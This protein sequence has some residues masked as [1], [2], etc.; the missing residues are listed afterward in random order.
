MMD[1]YNILTIILSG[2]TVGGIASAIVYRRQNKKL[3]ENEVTLSTVEAQRE[4]MN[5]GE[6]YIKKVMELSELNY[7]NTLK[8][9]KD[10]AVIIEKV[11]ELAAEQKNIVSYL[12][13]DYQEYLKRIGRVVGVFALLLVM[14]GCRGTRHTVEVPVYVHDTTY[15]AK[16]VHDSTYID[17]WHTVYVNGDT[18]R[19]HDS[20]VVYRYKMNTDPVCKYIEKPVTVTQTETVEVEKP[21]GWWQRLQRTGFWVLLGILLLGLFLAV[22]P[23]VLPTKNRN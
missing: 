10:N 20:I 3:K 2:T 8:N 14:T 5:L 11:D 21:L 9:G 6:D 1:L 18:V 17:K 22:L 4:Q 13:G 7:Q 12:N 23:T 16:E 15:I 19:T